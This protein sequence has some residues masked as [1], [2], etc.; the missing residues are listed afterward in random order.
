MFRA[1][2]A[3][4]FYKVRHTSDLKEYPCG[5]QQDAEAALR[6]F[7]EEYGPA[8]TTALTT[9]A[10]GPATADF[11]LIEQERRDGFGLHEIGQIV[12]HTKV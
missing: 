11:V 8:V 12:L 2:A 4:L 1:A 9:E 7:N 10:T 5:R 3:M 6:Y